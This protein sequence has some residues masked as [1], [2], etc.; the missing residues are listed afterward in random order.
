MPEQVGSMK[1][2]EV[3]VGLSVNALLWEGVDRAHTCHN[4]GLGKWTV[5]ALPCL[6][7]KIRWEQAPDIHDRLTPVGGKGKG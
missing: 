4:G 1:V 2:C 6:K 3:S 7:S 5:T